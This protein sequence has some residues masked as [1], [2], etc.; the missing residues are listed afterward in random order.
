MLNRGRNNNC[1]DY[2]LRPLVKVIAAT[3]GNFAIGI[4][5][6]LLDVGKAFSG[7]VMPILDV[8]STF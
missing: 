8:L 5:F 3:P 7:L 4:Q 6:E 1:Q 2:W